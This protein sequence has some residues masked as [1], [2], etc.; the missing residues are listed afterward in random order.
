VAGLRWCTPLIPALGRQKQ[1]DLYEFE[2]SPVYRISS[3]TARATQREAVSKQQQQQQP[4][5]RLKPTQ[6][7]KTKK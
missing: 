7:N 6:T 2:A 3:R 4:K 1:E 5:P